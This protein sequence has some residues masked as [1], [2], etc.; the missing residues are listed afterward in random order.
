MQIFRIDLTFPRPFRTRKKTTQ[1]AKCAGVI[2]VK[3]SNKVYLHPDARPEYSVTAVF[4]DILQV[5]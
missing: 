4:H 2:L 5:A 3:P 1:V